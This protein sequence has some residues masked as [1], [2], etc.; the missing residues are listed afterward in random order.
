[1]LGLLP[2]WTAHDTRV[3]R[4]TIRCLQEDGLRLTLLL[5]PCPLLQMCLLGLS[6][7]LHQR[8]LLCRCLL[9]YWCLLRCP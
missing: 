8:L 5:H 9:L 3:C 4:T 7:L 2:S 6:L 1:M